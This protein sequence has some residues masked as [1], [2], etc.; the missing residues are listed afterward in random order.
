MKFRGGVNALMDLFNC[1]LIRFVSIILF[2]IFF[3]VM[4]T[5]LPGNLD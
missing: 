2:K 1:R 4:L 3:S 5:T